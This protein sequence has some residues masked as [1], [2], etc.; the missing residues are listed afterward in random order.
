[1]LNA[2]F[3]EKVKTL[4]FGRSLKEELGLAIIGA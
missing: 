3:R 2:R 4:P 1:V